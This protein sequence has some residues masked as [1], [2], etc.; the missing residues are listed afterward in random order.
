MAMPSL[1]DAILFSPPCP[2]VA[3]TLSGD[4]SPADYATQFAAAASQQ[5]QQ[6]INAKVSIARAQLIQATTEAVTDRAVRESVARV[7]ASGSV[8]ATNADG[9]AIF[10]RPR[11]VGRLF[12]READSQMHAC[13]YLHLHACTY[14]PF[15]RILLGR[16]GGTGS[17]LAHG[18][19]QSIS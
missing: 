13:T 15:A 4:L 10:K 3:S 2:P 18:Y 6:A 1:V 17:V 11:W 19:Q 9:A 5:R 14:G 7:T 16:L 8:Q 12:C